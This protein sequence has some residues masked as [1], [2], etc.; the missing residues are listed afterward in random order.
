M[1]N[2]GGKPLSFKHRVNFLLNKNMTQF[3]NFAYQRPDLPKLT[4][5]IK[6][7][8]QKIKSAKNA[9]DQLIQIQKINTIRNDFDTMWNLAQIRHTIDTNDKSYEAENSFFDKKT[10]EFQGII[11][12][13]Y[14]LIV[15]SPFKDELKDKLGKQFFSLAELKV[16]TFEPSILEDLKRENQLT[17]E[18]VK[19]SSSALL[20]FEGKEYNLS[21]LTPFMESP[22]QETR[23]QAN[24]VYWSFYAKHSKEFD[25]IYDDLVLTRHKMAQK[26][27]YKNFIELGYA[28]MLRTDYSADEVKNFRNVVLETVVP[29]AVQLRKRQAKRIGLPKLNYFDTAFN[30]KTG[31]ATPKGS[32]E[33]IV[34][35]GKKMYEELSPET[36][37][38]FNYMLDKDLLDLVNKKGKAG[39]GYCTYIANEK[40]P[41]IFSNFNG[42]SHDIDVLTH[43]A[44]HAFQVY[45]SRNFELPEY[46]WPTMEACEIHSMSMEFLTWPWMKYFFQEDVE[47]YKFSHL[48]SAILFLPYGV[49]VD[50]Y[51]HM[52]YENPHASSK[53]RKQMWRTIEKKY[54]P[55]L[56]YGDNEFLNNGG[57]WQKQSHIFEMPFYYIDYT[58]AQIC[59]FQFWHKSRTQNGQ[60]FKDYLR[61]CR[62]GGSMP[63]LELV[64]HANL[65]SPFNK[66]SV[67]NIV[68]EVTNYLESVNDT[69]L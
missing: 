44:G 59:A 16:K 11:N 60:A 8:L 14:K 15:K 34:S 42:T 35:N 50:E 25:R 38:F 36:G 47:K 26:L 23:K 65:E 3:K 22:S 54:M 66:A 45:E 67:S 61:L 19:L 56:D 28:R 4:V 2:K 7:I 33:W 40:S 18:Y 48:S 68:G 41:F 37:N 12:D 24:K 30:F 58:L 10:P 51:Q 29:L 32:P 46:N 53:E 62:A 17:S 64:K 27:G 49:A 63:F 39:G 6:E 13:F 31:N 9:Q 57:F 55:D 5:E 1:V 43:E 20:M 21:G 69:Q 52:V